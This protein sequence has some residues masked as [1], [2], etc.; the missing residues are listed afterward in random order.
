MRNTSDIELYS[1]KEETIE[2]DL[3]ETIEKE[4]GLFRKED[5]DGGFK[6]IKF[7]KGSQSLIAI[8]DTK[9]TIIDTVEN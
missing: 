9:V 7:T 8:S 5:K 1:I 2:T 6:K 3:L 4:E